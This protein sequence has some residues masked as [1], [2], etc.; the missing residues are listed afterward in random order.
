MRLRNELQS[1]SNSDTGGPNRHLVANCPQHFLISSPELPYSWDVNQEN[2]EILRNDDP[3][4]AELESLGYELVGKSWGAHLNIEEDSNIGVLKKK[5][6]RAVERGY[7]IQ[8]LSA[9]AAQE[10]F[11]LEVLNNA[12]Y[13]Y[14]P[15]TAHPLPTIEGTR[16]LWSPNTWIFGARADGKLIAVCATSKRRNGT[17]LDF[18]SVHP[19]HRGKGVGVGVAAFGIL[20]L[21]S[22]GENAFSTGG[23]QINISSK[24]TVE[25]LG[26]SVDEIWHSY[27]FPEN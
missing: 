18:G 1:S 7:S 8:M 21:H 10:L 9:D 2:F 26:F 15:A 12:D 13:P 24:S 3:R 27:I 20:T 11:E 4:C 25:A 17:E 6:D 22:M 5:V 14:T 23:A 19:D 16:A